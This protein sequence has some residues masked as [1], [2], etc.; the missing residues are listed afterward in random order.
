MR[1]LDLSL[2]TRIV[3]LPLRGLENPVLARRLPATAVD[4]V[5]LMLIVSTIPV[6]TRAPVV[7]VKVISATLATPL[8]VVVVTMTRREREVDKVPDVAKE[9]EMAAERGR[10]GGVVGVD[11]AL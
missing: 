11:R 10:A 9:K 3:A 1:P 5:N 4:L 7:N 6:M 8:A 2:A